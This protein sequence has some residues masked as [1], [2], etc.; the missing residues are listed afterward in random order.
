V[1]VRIG[2][3]SSKITGMDDGKPIKRLRAYADTS[4]FGGVFDSKFKDASAMFFDDSARGRFQLVLSALSVQELLAAP[5]RVRTVLDGLTPKHVEIHAV[6]EEME[7][8]QSAYLLAG[9]LG[10]ASEDDALHVAAATVLNADMIVSWNFKH[11]VHFEKI[12][13]FNA[14]NRLRGYKTI[15]IY[16]PLE[17]VS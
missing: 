5:E 3:L 13:G 1:I 15:E 2:C 6:T 4:V 10:P 7:A 16:S 17:V 12:R 11:I 14:V 9:I 8:L